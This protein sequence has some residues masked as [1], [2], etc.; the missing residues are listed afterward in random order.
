MKKIPGFNERYS[1]TKN[2]EI[3]SHK[4]NKF[5]KPHRD[6]DGYKRISLV[7]E[8]GKRR[9]FRVARLVGITY[10]PNQ[11]EIINHINGIKDDDRVENL[12]WVTKSENRIHAIKT[13]L[14]NRNRFLYEIY[15]ENKKIGI[16]NNYKECCELLNCGKSSISEAV[17]KNK[18]VFG[19]FKIIQTYKY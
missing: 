15:D 12:E 18:K 7:D 9:G 14:E 16:C 17:N 19:R 8:N 11:K 4:R 3:F 10:I 6:K 5:M 1:I 2:G 13:G